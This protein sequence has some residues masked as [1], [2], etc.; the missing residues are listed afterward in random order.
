MATNP[1]QR[2]A[3]VSFL[4]GVVIT[5]L[6]AGAIIALLLFQLKNYRDKEATER[7][8]KVNV[9][10]L[11]ADVES[12]QVITKDMIVQKQLDKTLLPSNAFGDMSIL[13]NYALADRNGNE[14]WTDYDE[15]NNAILKIKINNRIYELK[16]TENGSYNYYIKTNDGIEEIKLIEAAVVAKVRMKKNSVLTLEMISKSNEQTT[17]DL[18]KQE[19]N[20]LVLPTQ[21]Q[22]GDYIDI[23]LAMPTGEDYIV[24]SKKQVQIPQIGG[25][26]SE[27]TIWVKLSEEEIITMNN[28]IVD[29]WGMLGSKLYVTIYTEA[30]MQETAKPTYVP[31]E[32]VMHLIDTNDN[33][34]EKAKNELK[35]RYNKQGPRVR[36][37]SIDPEIE[38]NGE[39]GQE[40]VKT[41]VDESSASSKE[42][43]KQYLQSLGG[44]Y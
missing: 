34:I 4:L 37:E 25:I 35:D 10:V 2:K 15:E 8:N 9:Y 40:N 20:M 3:R 30:G 6:V 11:N 24:V 14:V 27:S 17:N 39:E 33:I 29:A 5:L 19:Y 42:E 18:R 31:K 26:D 41:K 32:S 16:E 38:K 43:R 21:L 7:A 13:D 36:N 23:R 28:A 22:T 12:G 44:D 1:M